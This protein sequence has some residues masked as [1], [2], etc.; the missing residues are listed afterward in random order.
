MFWGYFSYD[1]KGPC[2]PATAAR[3]K[4]ADVAIAVMNEELE[5]LKKAAWE[6]ESG[7]TRLGLRARP[8]P[9]PKWKFDQKTGKLARGGGKGIDWWRYK[10]EILLPKLLPFAKECEKERY[11]TMVQENRALAHAHWH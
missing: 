1:K 10:E 9:K 8:G 2:H 5:P 7:M 6:L 3:R 11:N 4:A